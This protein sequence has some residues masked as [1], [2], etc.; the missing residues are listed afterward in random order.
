MKNVQH[1]IRERM[2]TMEVADV[3][4]HLGVSGFRQARTLADIVSY[5]WL[6]VELVRA[7]ADVLSE[8]DADDSDSYM[9]KVLPCFPAIR[10]TSNHYCLMGM[11]KDLYG[12]NERTLT[13]NNWRLA[14]KAVRSHA[15]DSS[16]VIKVLDKARI[17]KMVVAYRDG[18]PDNS[19]RF[20]PYEYG[21]YMFV[22]AS[23]RESL[24][25]FFGSESTLPRNADE[26]K[27][28]I[29]KRVEALK[30]EHGVRVLHIWIRDTWSYKPWEERDVDKMLQRVC[31]GETLNINEEDRL[32]SFSADAV[33]EAAGRNNMV[34]QLFHGMWGYPEK[35][36]KSKASF[37]NPDFLR[38]L[39]GYV[40]GHPD[41]VFDIFLGTRIPSHEAASIARTSRNLVVSGGW[42]QAF[43]PSTLVT[44]FRDRLEMLP[45]TAWNAFFS[46]GY[47]VEWV[48]AKLLLTKSCLARALAELVDEDFLT[49]DDALNVAQQLLHDNALK[50]YGC[51]EGSG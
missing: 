19:G 46:D 39:P 32:I 24:S 1:Q 28:G 33:A 16:W 45:N 13:E 25:T 10:N 38:R 49:I 23:S 8:K 5:H 35:A 48:Y 43:T 4:T 42:W 37:W 12:F 30:N 3:H 22:A 15:D 51:S 40:A 21:E 20:I 27:A 41:T 36:P 14:D 29:E 50:I 17:N 9:E 18:M 7:G 2:D 34:I 6:N 47:I 26:I 11:L 44:F 31:K